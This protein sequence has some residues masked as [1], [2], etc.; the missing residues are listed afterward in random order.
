MITTRRNGVGEHMSNL[1]DCGRFPCPICGLTMGPWSR[2]IT[3]HARKHDL[4]L[5]DIWLHVNNMHQPPTCA[6]SLE[7][8]KPVMWISWENGYQKFSRGHYSKESRATAI[9]KLQQH[10][11]D[12]HWARGKTN[13][14]DERILAASEKRSATMKQKFASG[15]ITSWSSGLTA[16]DHPTLKR[17]SEN[18]KGTKYHFNNIDSL[19]SKLNEKLEYRFKLLTSIDVISSRK[20][21]KNC[22]IDIRCTRCEN[23]LKISVTN[24]VRKNQQYCNN[25]DSSSSDNEEEIAEF[26]RSL[27]VDVQQRALIGNVEIDVYSKENLFGV[28]HDGL[29]WHSD[30]I[31]DNKMHHQRKTNMCAK[32]GIKLFHVFEDEWNTKRDIIKSMICVELQKHVLKIDSNTCNIISVSADEKQIFFDKNHIDGD[33]I[34]DMTFGLT[35]Q[36]G[37][38]IACMSVRVENNALHIVRFSTKLNISVINSLNALSKYA[39]L[40]L[41]TQTCKTIKLYVD[42]RFFEHQKTYIDLGWQYDG[43]LAQ[44]FWFTDTVKKVLPQNADNVE[45]KRKF[46]IYGCKQD[47]FIMKL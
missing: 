35:T 15:E 34:C 2:S 38:L 18:M 43:S 20:N 47:I 27:N 4:T 39:L 33:A 32:L 23:V 10:L 16:D 26:I 1:K 6:C 45:F 17:M 21:N 5:Q 14:N 11:K 24:V 44:N 28:E 29:Y 30:A 46:K 37:E 12:H 7:C 42:Q 19:I 9:I 13:E 3:M 40:K 8:V 22:L 31:Q 36:I 25:C 41:S